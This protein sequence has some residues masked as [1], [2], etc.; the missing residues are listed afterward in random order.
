GPAPVTR[1]VPSLGVDT[2]LCIS[3]GSYSLDGTVTPA[4]DAYEWVVNG[5]VVSGATAAT[6]NLPLAVGTHEV[7]VR[8]IF[9]NTRG[10]A[11]GPMCLADITADTVVVTVSPEPQAAIQVGTTIYASGGTHNISSTTSPVSET[12]TVSSS[13]SGNS[14][15]WEL[16]NP[17]SNTADA[18]GTGSSF[19][20]SFPS[21]GVYTLIL[22]STNGACED[23]DTLFVNV[24]ISTALGQAAGSFSAFPNPTTGSFTVVAPSAGL[25]ELRIIDIAGKVV[26]T[27]YVQGERKDLHLRLPAGTYQLH[28]SGEGRSGVIRLFIVE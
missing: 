16:Y 3:A 13:T 7:I 25:Y 24:S 10:L 14:Y 8:A 15:Q 22:I 6:Y 1:P 21:S 19:T 4:P 5:N 20:H 9:N 12:F 17:G 26:F 11:N 28:L 27:D 18:T 2:S 23:R